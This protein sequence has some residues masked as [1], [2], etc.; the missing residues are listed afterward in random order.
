MIEDS[1]SGLRAGRAAG[2]TVCMVP[3]LIPFDESLRP[4]CDLVFPS[5]DALEERLRE[6]A[7]RNGT[8]GGP[9]RHG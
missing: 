6:E 4:Y 5:L 2:M 8:E 1:P 9:A 7:A 3:D